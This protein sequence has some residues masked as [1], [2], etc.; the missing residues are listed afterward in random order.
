MS[1]SE[2]RLILDQLLQ[3]DPDLEGASHDDQ[4]SRCHAAYYAMD[5]CPENYSLQ[6]VVLATQGVICRP[7][8]TPVHLPPYRW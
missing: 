3:S 8:K 2:M 1:L 5:K 6:E 4:Y 7:V